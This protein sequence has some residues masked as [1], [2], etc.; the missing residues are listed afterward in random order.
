MPGSPE[1]IQQSRFGPAGSRQG[2]RPEPGASSAAAVSGGFVRGCWVVIRVL[3]CAD[4]HLGRRSTHR[5]AT[6]AA[7]LSPAAAWDRAVDAAIDRRVDAM[8]V[9]GDLVDENNAFYEALVPLEKAAAKLKEAGIPLVL[10]AGNHDCDVLRHLSDTVKDAVVILGRNGRWESRDIAC[11]DGRTLRLVGWSF[12]QRAVHESPLSA[13]PRDLVL[14]STPTIGLLHA[15][16]GAAGGRYCPVRRADLE[17]IPL[18][19]WVLGHLH[20]PTPGAEHGSGPAIFYTGSLQG[21]DPGPGEQGTHGAWL[22]TFSDAGFEAELLPLAGVVYTTL[23][24]D[25]SGTTL[26]GELQQRLSAALR[27]EADGV[28]A[29]NPFCRCLVVRLSVVGRSPLQRELIEEQLAAL[30]ESGSLSKDLDIVLDTCDMRVLPPIDMAA[31][32]HDR[33]PLGAAVGVWRELAG[34]MALR[35]DTAEAIHRLQQ[36]LEE[37][38]ARHYSLLEPWK[39]SAERCRQLLMEQTEALVAA[40]YAQ[41]EVDDA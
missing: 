1:T 8:T 33:T 9:S 23:E 28:R 17:A 26:V 21:L 35:P 29:E 5:Q 14:P 19:A 3:A 7:T 27:G 13:F 36:E 32:A 6:P 30:R 15:D 24:V 41:K 31:L 16:L 22:L 38:S 4:V 11:R 40:L 10:V 37:Y 20:Q 25:V 34:E 12:P 2:P 18:D 39:I